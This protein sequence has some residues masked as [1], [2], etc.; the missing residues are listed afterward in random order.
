MVRTLSDR[1][2]IR[3]LI[4]VTASLG[5]PL[6]PG[7]KPE[8]STKI[9]RRAEAD[10]SSSRLKIGHL[11]MKPHLQ[12]MDVVN[13]HTFNVI[14]ALD[15]ERNWIFESMDKLPEGTEPQITVEER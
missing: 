6:Q 13:G 11:L 1:E 5:I 3:T 12:F 2:L 10:V 8:A 4:N 14:L 9:T 15:D 7:G